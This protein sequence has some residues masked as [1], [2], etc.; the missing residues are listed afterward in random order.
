MKSTILLIILS[1]LVIQGY[2][3]SWDEKIKNRA[4]SLRKVNNKH[5][6]SALLYNSNTDGLIYVGLTSSVEISSFFLGG[7]FKLYE[8]AYT[9]IYSVSI[10]GNYKHSINPEQDLN[11]NA[12]SVGG[13]FTFIGF[14]GTIYF[15]E[16]TTFSY[17][18]PKI[19]FE[20]WYLEY[21]L[22]LWNSSN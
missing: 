18:N 1:L 14:E 5:T 3:Q 22:W 2:S 16:E 10:Y 9:P 20:L 13:H 6:L 8:S 15:N 17:L 11:Y 19:G 21:I 7:E 12:I 4:D